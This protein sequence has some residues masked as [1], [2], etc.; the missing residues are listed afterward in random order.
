[1]T[2]PAVKM[3]KAALAAEARKPRTLRLYDAVEALDIL[4]DLIDEHSAQII[5]G[6]GDIE[7]VPEIAELLAFAEDQFEASVERWAQ[8]I[9]SL[10]LEAQ[11]AQE[12]ADRI[13]H[14]AKTKTN[15]VTGLKSYLKRMLEIRQVQKIQFPTIRVRIQANS[16][17]AV[18]ATS[19]TVIETLYA[20]GSELIKRKET[21]DLDRDKILALVAANEPLPEGITVARGTHLRVE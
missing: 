5:L 21:F 10:T 15:T 4:D 8:K 3:D 6:G 13:A 11:A 9:R 1:M 12:E 19:E 17:P 16:A 18:T 14:I 20:Q 7:S 2:A